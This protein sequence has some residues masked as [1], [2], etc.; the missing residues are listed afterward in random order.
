MHCYEMK[1]DIIITY[2]NFGVG[3]HLTIVLLSMAFYLKFR[4]NYGSKVKHS[5]VLS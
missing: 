5:I 2:L 1:N 3:S 4:L